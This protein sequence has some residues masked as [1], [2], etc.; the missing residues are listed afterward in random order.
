MSA[1]FVNGY[2][3]AMT[4]DPKGTAEMSGQ[5]LFAGLLALLARWAHSEV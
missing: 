4:L 5:S 3:V 1:V 2:R